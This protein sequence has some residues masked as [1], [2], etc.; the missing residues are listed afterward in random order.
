MMR[1]HPLFQS[2][3]DLTAYNTQSK[4]GNLLT[5]WHFSSIRFLLWTFVN[6]LVPLRIFFFVHL[7]WH[8]F[9]SC[10]LW[11]FLWHWYSGT[12][13]IFKCSSCRF[14]RFFWCKFGSCGFGC[15]SDK[16]IVSSGALVGSSHW[17]LWLL[18]DPWGRLSWSSCWLSSFTSGKI[19]CWSSVVGW[20][21][22]LVGSSLVASV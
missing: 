16:C 17:Q 1:F 5:V 10:F 3:D 21:G 6:T 7:C 18:T 8:F 12:Q 22:V 9:F 14:S 13:V 4:G 15:T 19:D 11:S 2:G 20:H